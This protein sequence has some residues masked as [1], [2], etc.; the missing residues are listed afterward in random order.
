[1]ISLNYV[2]CS[3]MCHIVICVIALMDVRRFQFCYEQPRSMTR[4][5]NVPS[6]LVGRRGNNIILLIHVFYKELEAEK[7][8]K[9]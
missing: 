6:Y 2:A 1:M 5:Q 9:K 8:S 7:A 3:G 4:A